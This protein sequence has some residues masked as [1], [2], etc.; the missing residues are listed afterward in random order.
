MLIASPANADSGSCVGTFTATA[1][2]DRV[3]LAAGATIPA[4]GCVLAVDVTAADAGEYLNTIPVG[5]LQTSLGPNDQPAQATLKVSTLGYISGKVFLDNQTVPDG[6]FLPGESSPIIGNSVELRSGASCGG[7][8]IES[9]TTDAGGNYLFSDLPAGTYSVCQP[10]QPPDTLNSVTTEGTIVPFGASTGTPGTAANP[11]A[12]TSQITGIVLG[13]NAGNAGEVS[14]SPYNNFSEVLPAAL[15]GN[16]YFDRNDDGIRDP[17]EPGIG[18]VEIRLSGPVTLTTI[19]AP[20]GSWSFTGLPPGDYTVT[21]VQPG[22]WLDGQDSR[23]TV[24]ATPLGDDSISDVISGITLGPGATG[25][26]YNFGEIAPANL[27]LN[28]NA[29]CIN[30]VPYVDYS[31]AGFSGA[32]SPTVT[33]TWVTPGGR[34]AEELN[35]QPGNGRLLW[36]GAAVDAA[37]NG[38][39]W[40]GWAFTDG[41]W[42]EVADDRRP[43]MTVEV[44]F[45]PSG[46]VSVSYPPATS[47]CAAQPSGTFRVESV[48]ASPRWLLMLTA[49]F[50]LIAAS[51]RIIVLR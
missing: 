12:S 9:T 49:M 41:R 5:A 3:S 48:P 27:T 30:D 50:L 24:G 32:S 43:D 34:V 10:S 11:S 45:N 44:Q 39:G 33:V 4:G 23:G 15:S 42:V 1:G 20:D 7:A 40:P 36:P 8:L 16:V 35:N 28:A 47:A 18:G 22:G 31:I 38:T 14:G 37:G 19:T 21:E 2:A 17:G 26:E 46:T 6:I 13:D 29:V 51:R 25:I